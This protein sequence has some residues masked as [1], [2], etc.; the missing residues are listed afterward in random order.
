MSAP[1]TSVFARF[2]ELFRQIT[3]L[4]LLVILGVVVFEPVVPGGDWLREALGETIILRVCIAALG[5]YVILLWGESL[6]L[7]A[8]L[9]GVL[10]AFREHSGAGGAEAEGAGKRNPKARLEAAKLLVAALSADDE[11]IRRTSH[12]NL[13]RLVGKDLGKEPGP[14]LRWVEQQDKAQ[15]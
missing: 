13:Q 10:R 12:H 9:T 1:E 4:F 3:P 8:L 2:D 7:N 5:L 11:E 14:W 15:K 6:R